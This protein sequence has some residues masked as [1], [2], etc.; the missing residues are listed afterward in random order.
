MLCPLYFLIYTERTQKVRRTL[1]FEMKQPAIYQSHCFERRIWCC[2]SRWMMTLNLLVCFNLE[3]FHL[4]H[5][6]CARRCFKM[7]MGWSVCVRSNSWC[8]IFNW[9]N[10]LCS[11][12]NTNSRLMCLE[13]LCSLRTPFAEYVLISNPQIESRQTH[14]HLKEEMVQAIQIAIG[15]NERGVRTYGLHRQRNLLYVCFMMKWQLIVLNSAPVFNFT[16]RFF[17]FAS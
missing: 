4:Q 2:V 7:P 9:H 15:N 6:A 10:I 8:D 14:T 16:F 11:I 13:T 12:L 17:L 3:F 1:R 5:R